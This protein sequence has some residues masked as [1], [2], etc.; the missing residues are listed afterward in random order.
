MNLINY[1]CIKGLEY[2]KYVLKELY[3]LY[4]VKEA[5]LWKNV[6]NALLIDAGILLEEPNKIIKKRYNNAI[7]KNY[8]ILLDT[9]IDIICR[10]K[11]NTILLV[12]CKAYSSKIYQKH[13]S[14]FYR[15]ILDSILINKKDNVIGLIAHT[16]SLCEIITTSYSFKLNIIQEV[17]IPFD[18]KKDSNKREGFRFLYSHNL[19]FLLI[20]IFLLCLNFFIITKQ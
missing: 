2:E 11:N 18:F 8:N 17:K 15:T 5:F 9:G 20:N 6:P 13:L 14:G 4:N 3:R 1:N 10:L 16:S 12:Q 19:Q 7:T